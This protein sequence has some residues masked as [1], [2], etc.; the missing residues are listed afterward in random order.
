MQTDDVP[1]KYV[2]NQMHENI[3]DDVAI[4]ATDGRFGHRHCSRV[5]V[6]CK[7]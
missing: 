4:L 1:I 7:F 6:A 5:V 3:E 2:D